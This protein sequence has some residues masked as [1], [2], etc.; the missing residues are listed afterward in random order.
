MEAVVWSFCIIQIH[1]LQSKLQS[2]RN[3]QDKLTDLI[4]RFGEL[5][6]RLSSNKSRKHFWSTDYTPTIVL[7]VSSTD[8]NTPHRWELKFSDKLW[9][10]FFSIIHPRCIK[11]AFSDATVFIADFGL[12]LH[13]IGSD[14]NPGMILEEPSRLLDHDVLRSCLY[15]SKKNFF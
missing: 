8:R 5:R 4:I 13:H 10:Y 6:F 3:K 1:I 9:C 15:Q 12:F 14:R 2:N 7:D 11:E